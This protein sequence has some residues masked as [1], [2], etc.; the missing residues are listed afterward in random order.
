MNTEWMWNNQGLDQKWMWP[1]QGLAQK[2]IW[3][4]VLYYNKWLNIRPREEHWAFCSVN[5]RLL[6]VRVV[7][8]M[9]AVVSLFS[10][11]QVSQTGK[12]NKTDSPCTAAGKKR[13]KNDKHQRQYLGRKKLRLFTFLLWRKLITNYFLVIPNI[14]CTVCQFQSTARDL[15][16]LKFLRT[17]VY[18]YEFLELPSIIWYSGYQCTFRLSLIFFPKNTDNER[19]SQN[20]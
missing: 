7:C 3:P 15:I 9:S 11:V 20:R 12:H 8:V 14:I 19:G 10:H 5:L 6:L 4:G 1:N 18:T 2:W 13:W 16:N 17:E